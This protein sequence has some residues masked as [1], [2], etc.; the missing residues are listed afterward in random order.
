MPIGIRDI[1]AAD[2][3]QGNA[4]LGAAL[5]SP[6]VLDTR[7][8]QQLG[9]YSF[10]AHREQQERVDKETQAKI[11][12]L[13]TISAIDWQNAIPKEK[14]AA[15]KIVETLKEKGK[16][17]ASKPMTP[18]QV[19][20]WQFEVNK[21]K[22]EVG[23]INSRF[24]T[25][26]EWNKKIEDATTPALKSYYQTERD[27]A[28]NSTTINDP[29]P[30]LPKYDLKSPDIKA[31][32][33]VQ[34]DVTLAD[35]KGNFLRDRK[36]DIADMADVNA[37]ATAIELGLNRRQ[38]DANSAEFKNLSPQEQTYRQQQAQLDEATGNLLTLQQSKDYNTVLQS[39]KTE[40]GIDVDKIR[41]SNAILAGVMDS[42]DQYNSYVRS[43]KEQIKSGAF[44]DKTGKAYQFGMGNLKESDYQ[45]ISYL[46]G[47]ISPSELLKVQI[48]GL[49]EP[50]KYETTTTPTDNAIQLSAQQID[51]EQLYETTRHN[52][53]TEGLDRQKFNLED[54]KWQKSLT[55]SD[56]QINGAVE[57]AKR[58]KADLL[59]LAD[60]K[61]VISPK[62]IRR[63][64]VEQLK[65]LG[66][67]KPQLDIQ[68]KSPTGQPIFTPLTLDPDTEYAIEIVGDEI[69]VLKPEE[70]K[71]LART[72]SGNYEGLFDP[73]LS[74]NFR[75]VGVNILNEELKSAGSKELNAYMGT[76]V[77]GG[78]TSNTDIRTS[79]S[80]SSSSAGS[81]R[82]E[83][84]G[85][86]YEVPASA[87][88]EM[89]KDKIKYKRLN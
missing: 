63:L 50:T 4:G 61:G 18:A 53:A 70:G 58:I 83:V 2:S 27:K 26:G 12:E 41:S 52:K 85:K 66:I 42:M 7:P 45:E 37:Q 35:D 49:A 19:L 59:K 77:Y 25:Y 44:K 88:P 47:N 87:L 51:R 34:F 55:G 80:S 64:N 39:Y 28:V 54:K 78:I 71:K 86:I 68:T 48:L 36:V 65:Y 38:L 72:K 17:F 33:R 69:R 84:G 81:V 43:L 14:E 30:T 82:V 32:K 22:K 20:D 73:T 79:T 67:E 11:K 21:A 13:S 1:T 8:I 75:N 57:R 3:Y 46:D 6:I 40:A 5:D 24:I 29:L 74:T 31:P 23:N 89:D 10:Y 9:V 62:N 16:A 76:D 60:N 15:L 56:T